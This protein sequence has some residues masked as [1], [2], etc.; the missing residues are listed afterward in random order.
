MM[1]WEELVVEARRGPIP[2][3]EFPISCGEIREARRRLVQSPRTQIHG[4]PPHL[5]R[6]AEERSSAHRRQLFQS[7]LLASFVLEPNLKVGSQHYVGIVSEFLM[8]SQIQLSSK[9]QSK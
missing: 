4:E 8:F 2:E 1:S 9:M 5:A 3:L 6:V 7:P